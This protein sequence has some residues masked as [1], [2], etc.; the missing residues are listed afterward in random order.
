MDI[1]QAL[2]DKLFSQLR[3]IHKAHWKAPK[4]D[5]VLR[6]IKEK[7]VFVFRIGAEPHVAEVKI[8]EKGIFYEINASLPERMRKQAEEMK[9]KFN[10]FIASS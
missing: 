5:E 9:K 6:E 1:T 10:Q 2:L 3:V 4:A 8:S 7:G